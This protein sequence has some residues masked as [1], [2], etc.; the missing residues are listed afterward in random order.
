MQDLPRLSALQP[1]AQTLNLDPLVGDARQFALLFGLDATQLSD[2]D[3]LDEQLNPNQI[4]TIFYQRIALQLHFATVVALGSR[5]I[6]TTSMLPTYFK[7]LLVPLVYDIARYRMDFL[8]ARP[9][10]KARHDAAIAMVK[11]V[12]LMGAFS[13]I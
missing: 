12:P 11:E 2:L 1:V 10:G 3:N 8:V 4:E 6:S 9:D 13:T 7:K 5:G